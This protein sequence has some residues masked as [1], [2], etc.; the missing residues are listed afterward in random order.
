MRTDMAFS[1][2]D[3]ITASGLNEINGSASF[4]GTLGDSSDW[5]QDSIGNNGIFFSH[6]PAGS[7]L[8]TG[9]FKCGWLGGGKFRIKKWVSG[10]WNETVYSADFGWNT[11]TTVNV[12]STGP[13]QYRA[14]SESAFQFAAIPWSIF[15]GQTDCTTGKFLTVY[16]GFRSSINSLPGTLITAALCNSQRAGTLGI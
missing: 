5:I 8:F 16:D 3:L 15:C 11:K 10:G 4:S 9:Y 6:R 14:Y 7:L 12:S 1:S 13:G 2:G